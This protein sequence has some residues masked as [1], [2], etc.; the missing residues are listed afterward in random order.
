MKLSA[1]RIAHTL[2]QHSRIAINKYA[3]ANYL[4]FSKA[5]LMYLHNLKT[6]SLGGGLITVSTNIRVYILSIFQTPFYIIGIH[7][8]F[9]HILYKE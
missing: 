3:K 8:L 5:F 2:V 6:L 9:L 1:G 7:N 4:Q